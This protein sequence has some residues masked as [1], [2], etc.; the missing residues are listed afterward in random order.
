MGQSDLRCP[1]LDI[2]RT[3]ESPRLRDARGEAEDECR[4]RSCT[5]NFFHASSTI[6]ILSTSYSR[7]LASPIDVG[8]EY[9][10]F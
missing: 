7:Q 2:G 6:P 8:N 10:Q 9:A 4:A 5:N 3:E 1:L